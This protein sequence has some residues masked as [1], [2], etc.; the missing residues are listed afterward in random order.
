MEGIPIREINTTWL[1]SFIGVVG[2]EP[3][4]FAATIAENIRYGNPHAT[5]EGIIN[6]A[7]TANCHDFI[8]KLPNVHTCQMKT[9]TFI[10]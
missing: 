1:R 10:Q 2:Q 9:K 6:A 7:K 8:Q 5:M 4:L 3:V